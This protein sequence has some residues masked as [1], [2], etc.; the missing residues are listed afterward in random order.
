MN[1]KTVSLIG[2]ISL[3]VINALLFKIALDKT[4]DLVE[5]PVANVEIT[6]RSKIDNDMIALM[7]VPRLYLNE[8]T[9]QDKSDV[10]GLYTDIEGTIPKGSLL[11]KSLLFKE[12]DLPD[13]PS[14]KLKDGQNVFPLSTDLLKSSGNTFVANQKVDLHVSISRKKEAP[15]TDLFLKNVRVLNVLDR[16]GMD[17]QTSTTNIPYVINLAIDSQYIQDLK[18]ASELGSIDL[19]ASLSP[20]SDPE[21]ILFEESKVL[22]ELRDE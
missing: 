4:I 17:M 8:N 13:Y 7:K 1:K 5:V 15:L 21:C 19:Y 16:K 2:V 10:I 18:V 14:L 9:I 12:S 22:S 6:P 20:N 3:I 11:Y